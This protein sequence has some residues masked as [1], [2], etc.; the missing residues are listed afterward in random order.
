ML[1][2]VE[3]RYGKMHGNEMPSAGY[4]SQ[5]SEEVEQNDP[6]AAPLTEIASAEDGQEGA[7][8]STRAGP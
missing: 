8:A 4:L 6:K 5:K 3:S 1:R 7:Q 2:V